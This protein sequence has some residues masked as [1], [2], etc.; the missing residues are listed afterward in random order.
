MAAV[1]PVKFNF[2]QKFTVK[3]GFVGASQLVLM[4]YSMPFFDHTK[5]L[6]RKSALQIL[7]LKKSV[8]LQTL[9]RRCY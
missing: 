4:H 5:N 8:A 6:T 9:N 7:G 1:Y 2:C 3:V